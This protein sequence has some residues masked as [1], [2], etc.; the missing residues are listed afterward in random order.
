M[1]RILVWAI[2]AV[3]AVAGGGWALLNN[4]GKS[5]AAG[6]AFY[7]PNA[8]EGTVSV[9]DADNGKVLDTISLGTEQASHGIALSPDKGSLYSGT[10]FQG[11]SVVKIDTNTKKIVKQT[12][13]QEGV[14]GIDISPDGGKL[15]VSLNP[16]LGKKGGGLAVVD[17]LTMEQAALVET[18]EGPA[19][20]AVAADG[21]Q[22]WV[23]NVNGNT[24]SVVDAASN[25]LLKVIPVGQVPNEVALS[26]D[27]KLAFVGN[28]ESGS[29]TVIDA[30]SFDVIKEL[31]AGDAPH[32]VTVSPDGKEIWVANNESNDVSI[33]QA[34]TLQVVDTIPTGAYA[35]HVAFS[36]DGKWAFVT[37]RQ[38]NDVVKIDTAA[39]KVTARIPVGSEPHEISLEDYTVS[40]AP[41]RGNASSDAVVDAGNAAADPA[42]A[43]QGQIQ[44]A[45]SGGVQIEAERLLPTGVQAG[46]TITASDYEKYEIFRVS[47]T[48]HSGDLSSIPLSDNVF[49]ITD[50]GEKK[51]PDKW[52][53][54]S[55]DA[56]H[57]QYLAFFAKPE[58]SSL[59][60]A[61]LQIGG[62]SDETVTLAWK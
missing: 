14:H 51:A 22:V 5:D 24:V 49:R 18:G 47:L 40:S 38:S 60:R 44:T 8:G 31:R 13:F 50:A 57:P 10:G 17:T 19:H 3:V 42:A 6:L 34:A 33:I 7:V 58:N 20:V 15:Y 36:P 41:D 32:G 23:A 21:S 11:K 29:V 27:G 45:E 9:V 53:V 4:A 16:G 28:V 55:K 12:T 61:S 25:R 2:V 59:N 35:N 37:N 43:V 62:V 1:K 26:P 46:Q 52:V 48:A 39:R 54:E 30:Q 56:H